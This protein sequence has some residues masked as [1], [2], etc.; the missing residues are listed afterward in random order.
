MLASYGRRLMLQSKFF[1]SPLMKDIVSVNGIVF[2]K[3]TNTLVTSAT[4]FLRLSHS[5]WLLPYSPLL[6]YSMSS[7][8]YDCAKAELNTSSSQMIDQ[9]STSW[10][11]D[12]HSLHQVS[13]TSNSW[14]QKDIKRM[15]HRYW[16]SSF[17]STIRRK[18]SMHVIT[19]KL[20]YLYHCEGRSNISI[21]QWH[22]PIE[23]RSFQRCV[24]LSL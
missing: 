13:G 4:S 5:M 11:A 8:F 15:T 22:R 9:R 19:S 6:F 17:S 3:N 18:Q 7:K 24:D 16:N 10:F 21:P 12:S 1:T 23:M 2:E 14:F 20:C